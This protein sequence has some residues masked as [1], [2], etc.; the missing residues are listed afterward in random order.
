MPYIKSKD[1][2]RFVQWLRKT[3]VIK[4]KGELEYLVTVL[5][6]RFLADQ[7]GQRY[8]QIHDTVYAVI[9]AGEELRRIVMDP[10]EEEKRH[11]N[12]AVVAA[13]RSIFTADQ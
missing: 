1:R 13:G 10:Y 12:G 11:E 8:A 5:A 3:P 6:R 9:H 4:T 7:Q 2:K